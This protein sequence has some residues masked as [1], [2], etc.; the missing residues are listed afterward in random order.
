ML[1]GQKKKLQE[2]WRVLERSNSVLSASGDLK[3]KF[4]EIYGWVVLHQFYATRS[5]QCL[6]LVFFYGNVFLGVMERSCDYLYESNMF[7]PFG[8]A[9]EGAFKTTSDKAQ[10]MNF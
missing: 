5:R 4:L 1:Y 9:Y 3:G 2:F 10:P 6:V 7:M 8:K